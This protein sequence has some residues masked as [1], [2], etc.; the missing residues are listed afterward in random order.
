MLAQMLWLSGDDIGMV[1]A[2]VHPPKGE[3]PLGLVSNLSLEGSSPQW[4]ES[5]DR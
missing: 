1:Q 5:V 3:R 4:V 2:L